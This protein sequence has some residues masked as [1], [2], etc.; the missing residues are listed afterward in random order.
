MTK[1][2]IILLINFSYLFSSIFFSEYAEGSS[3]NK[4]LEIYNSGEE[5]VDLSNYTLS[6]C[7]NGCND[8]LNWDYPDNVTFSS[9]TMLM[10]NDVYV[11]CHGSADP[12]IALEC[13]QTFTY[14]SNGDDVFGLTT[15]NGELI[16]VIGEIGDDPGDGW[17]VAGVSNGTKDHTLVR[18]P[19][20]SEG[21]SGNWS[22]SAGTSESNSEW[23]VYDQNDWSYLGFHVCTVC[24]DGGD[25]PMLFLQS[26]SNGDVINTT[27]FSIVFSVF[28]FDLGEDGLINYEINGVTYEVDSA[29][30]IQVNNVSEG[31]YSLVIK[32]V[33]MDGNDLQPVVETSINFTVLLP[34]LVPI[35]EIQNNYDFYEGQSVIVQGVVTIGDGLLFPGRTKFYLQDESGKGIQIFSYDEITPFYQRGDLL[36]VA[37]VVDRYNDDVEIVDPVIT[38][39]GSNQPLPSTHEMTGVE[40][41]EMNGTWSVAS[42]ELIDYWYY[43]SGSTEFTA[44]TIQLNNGGEVQSMFWNSAVP[45]LQLAEYE[46]LLGT[47]Y[48]INGVVSFY[49]GIPQLTCGY[50]GD[51]QQYVDSSTPVANAGQNQVVLPGTS[52]ELNGEMSSDPDGI[53]VGYLWTQTSGPLVSLG[54][55]EEPVLTFTAPEEDCILEFSLV[56]TDNNGNESNPDIVQI[57]VSN[58][59]NIFDINLPKNTSLSNYPNPFNPNT[60]IEINM[61]NLENVDL[62]IYDINGRLIEQLIVNQ[63]LQRGTH[64]LFFSAQNLNSGVYILK[65][66]TDSHEIVKMIH[67]VK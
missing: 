22:Q 57:T 33:D 58:S 11:V 15:T 35:S 67:L 65:M 34:S 26:P 17:D 37:G 60:N 61:I 54:E 1:I 23:M 50:L 4:Y 12:Q 56:V 24:V 3:N 59:L 5:A 44:L 36:E 8:G 47:E 7:S 6:S 25:N 31:D 48:S 20:V 30:P 46:Q 14:L 19:T 52:V 45:A 63:P 43:V 13:D 27:E 64:N 41:T 66:R 28:N 49:N 16:D 10:P 29:D 2:L 53:I 39:L 9:N 32:L 18:M 40:N 21:N 38:L 55:Y 51:I 42:G 62:N